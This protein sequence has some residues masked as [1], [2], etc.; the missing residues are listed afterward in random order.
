LASAF[1]GPENAPP[2]TNIASALAPTTITAAIS[3]VSELI[4][5]RRRISFSDHVLSGSIQQTYAA[6][7]KSE[8]SSLSAWSSSEKVFFASTRAAA[9]GLY[10]AGRALARA[11]VLTDASESRPP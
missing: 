2:G 11:G 1:D 5:L 3:H 8:K 6:T 7:L 10:A 4:D 9:A